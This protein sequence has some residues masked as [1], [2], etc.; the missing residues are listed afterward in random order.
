MALNPFRRTSRTKK[1]ARNLLVADALYALFGS[2]SG[3]RSSSS[4]KPGRLGLLIGGASLAAAGVAGLLGRGKLARRL[5]GRSEEPAPPSAPVPPQPSNYDA[6]GPVGN[7]AT[8]IPAPDPSSPGI[9]EA[10]PAPRP[11]IDERAEEEAAA[12][13]AAAIGGTTSDYAGTS[14]DEPADEEL[15]PVVE[16]GGG[17]SEGQEQAEAELADNATM[18]DQ[19]PSD[20]ER[21]IDD[22]IEAQDEPGSGER[23]EP[24][25]PLGADYPRDDESGIDTP[26][27]SEGGGISGRPG[28]TLGDVD[29]TPG[30]PATGSPATEPQTGDSQPDEGDEPQTWSGRPA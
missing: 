8:P 5:P 27:G 3:S 17:E 14:L 18:R 23:P 10:G 7:T 20:A 4:R 15:R 16:A 25:S 1:V 29:E 21:Q 24:L 11:V 2:W 13:E 19:A 12:A 22:A 6:P 26:P 30:V 28:A 9:G